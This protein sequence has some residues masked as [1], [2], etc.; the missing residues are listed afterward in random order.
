MNYRLITSDFSPCGLCGVK[1]AFHDTDSDTDTDTDF[2]A[3][4]LARKSRIS[5]VRMYRHVGR[6][7]VGVG[8]GVVERQLNGR[9]F[10]CDPKVVGSNLDSASR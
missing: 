8:V 4:I 5:D 2:L 1:L 3:K 9:A 7:G 6:V 10:A